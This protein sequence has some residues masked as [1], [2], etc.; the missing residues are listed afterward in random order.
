MPATEI[1]DHIKQHLKQIKELLERRSMLDVRDFLRTLY[2]AEIAHILESLIPD[3]RAKIWSLIP[4]DVKGEIL[5]ELNT[6][7][8]QGL[9]DITSK[10]N[11]MAAA[12]G[13]E[14]DDL[15]DL[16]HVLP[17]TLAANILVS[18]GKEAEGRLESALSYD[19]D[20]AGGLMSLDAVTIRE[21]VTLEVISRYLRKLGKIPPATDRLYVVDRENYFLGGLSVSELLVK[22]PGLLV[23][24]LMDTNVKAIPYHVSA[25]EVAQI[26]A[27]RDILSAPI[28]SD[29]GRLLGRITIDDVV[30][31]IREEADH[32]LMSM[33][34]L[35]EEQDMFAPVRVSAQRRAVWL[36]VNLFTAFLA[37][38]VIGL[39]QATLEQIVAL[40]VLMPIVAS[41]GGIAGSQTLTIVIRGLA[42]DQISESNAG[43]LIIKELSVGAL[44]G[45][46]W[47]VIVAIIAGVWFQSAGIGLLLGCAMVINLVFAA[48][49]GAGIPMV[50]QRVGVD[51]A[52]AG[53]VLLTTI[54]DVVGFMAFLG[55]A[56]KFLL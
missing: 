9:I 8:A 22:D 38:W 56:T 20:S 36:G 19:D 13:L 16:L 44:N 41:M 18:M 35:D 39:Y 30:D 32:S 15:V 42:L 23:S 45:A 48:L 34:G 5:V 1:K 50:L 28:V 40:A 14:S 51:P 11:L 47:A 31:V 24:E 10:K 21:N 49:A 25:H 6:E 12:D 33:A 52:L 4:N 17:D 53:S 43:K 55:L 27:R 29:D 54:T 3:E 46:L 7:V 2:P 37:S 26:F